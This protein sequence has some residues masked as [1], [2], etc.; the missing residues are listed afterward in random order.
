MRDDKSFEQR[1]ES[2]G[3]TMVNLTC[4]SLAVVLLFLAVL[5]IIMIIASFIFG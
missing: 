5:V 1:A 4:G 2:F 3:N